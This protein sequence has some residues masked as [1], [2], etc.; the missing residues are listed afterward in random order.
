MDVQKHYPKALRE[1]LVP[2]AGLTSHPTYH[3]VSEH[4]M[5]VNC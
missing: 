1:M 3:V 2:K 5:S 4:I